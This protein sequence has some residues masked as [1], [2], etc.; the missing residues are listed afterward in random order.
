MSERD[1]PLVPTELRAPRGAAVV[2]ID[3][4]D[5]HQSRYEHELLRGFCPCAH[6]QG[7]H[8]PVRF[9]PSGAPELVEIAE[10][11]HYALRLGWGDGHTTGIYSFRFLRQLCPCPACADGEPKDRSFAR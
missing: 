8:G 4:P 2:E 11:G 5:G 6:C 9:V 10:V 1:R 3:W 7:H